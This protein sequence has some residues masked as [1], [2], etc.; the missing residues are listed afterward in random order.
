MSLLTKLILL[1]LAG[2]A[3]T[4]ARYGLAG[5]T[6]RLLGSAFPW[7]TA[8]VNLL[9][10]L[11]VGVFWALVESRWQLSGTARAMLFIGFMG[12]FTTFSSF[13]LESAELF[14]TGQM[15]WGLLNIAGQNVLGL[16]LFVA[17]YQAA[18]LMSGG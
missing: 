9:G 12:A 7:G 5:L 18:R 10:C 17:G 16:V 3:G 13:V 11:L 6:Q 2:A 15:A 1:A 8:V 14:R 4:I